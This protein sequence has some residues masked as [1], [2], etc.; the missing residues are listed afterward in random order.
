MKQ[1]ALGLQAR[2]QSDNGPATA[3]GLIERAMLA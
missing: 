2:M 1:A 3:A